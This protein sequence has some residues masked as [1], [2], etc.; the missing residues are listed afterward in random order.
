MPRIDW[1]NVCDNEPKKNIVFISTDSD[2]SKTVHTTENGNCAGI[3]G[4]CVSSDQILAI[5]ANL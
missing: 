5:V 1:F 2:G 3:K 4:S